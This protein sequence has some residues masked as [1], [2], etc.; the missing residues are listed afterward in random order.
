M[1]RLSA[2][3][4]PTGI[5]EIDR[6]RISISVVEIGETRYTRLERLDV[7]GMGLGDDLNVVLIAR[8]GSTSARFEVGTL[9]SLHHDNLPID[10]LDRS[11]PLRFRVLLRSKE[12]PRLVAV[13]EDLRPRDDGQSDSLL[14]ME[15]ADL[16]ERIWKLV[17]QDEEAVLQFNPRVF[18]N[19][20]GAENNRWF[21]AL[22]LPEALRQALEPIRMDPSKL[23]EGAGSMADWA[24]W[25]KALG[26][27]LPP[28][29][30]EEDEDGSREWCEEVVTLFCRKYRFA[31]QIHESVQGGGSD[32]G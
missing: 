4:N 11:Q 12:D 13:A 29:D 16:G 9:S 3:S 18:P 24:P 23:E 15:P 21:S 25:L 19:A 17:I 5:K 26:A 10:S 27:D 20:Q 7:E 30:P 14:L 6:K 32:Q 31:S 2:R 22:V 1:A 8:A 28:P